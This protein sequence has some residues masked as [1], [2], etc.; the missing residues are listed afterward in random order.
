MKVNRFNLSFIQNVPRRKAAKTIKLFMVMAG[1]D[2][3][4]S[5]FL[6]DGMVGFLTGL[7]AFISFWLATYHVVLAYLAAFKGADTLNMLLKPETIKVSK[8]GF[9]TRCS[10]LALSLLYAAEIE[11]LIG[12]AEADN[13]SYTP[14]SYSTKY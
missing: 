4:Q 8:R 11:H 9:V 1:L 14:A 6:E 7:F 13:M 3:L 2:I 10:L 5:F 12:K